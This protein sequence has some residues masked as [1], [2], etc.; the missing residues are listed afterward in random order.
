MNKKKKLIAVSVLLVVVVG[1]LIWYHLPVKT[2]AAVELYCDDPAAGALSA[3]LDLSISRSL[4]AQPAVNGTIRI[5]DTE[6]V[7]WARQDYGFFESIQRKFEGRLDIPAFINPDNFGHGTELMLSDLL[8]LHS[9]QF[10][11]GYEIENVSLLLT[12]DDYAGGLWSNL[13]V[14][15]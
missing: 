3:E 6:Y 10:G 11:P 5:G 15:S 8:W 4:L 7:V 14:T 1:A 13:T 9:I 12:S 2:S